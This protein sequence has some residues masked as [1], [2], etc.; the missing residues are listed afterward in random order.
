MK[1]HTNIQK[2][3]DK[4]KD[5]SKP[6]DRYSS[7]DYCYNYFLKTK[8]KDI[9]NNIEKSCLTLGF[10]LA[11]WG[12]FRNSFLLDKSIKHYEPTVR[13]IASL[14]KKI[15]KI[16]VDKYTVENIEIILQIYKDLKEH[17]GVENKA[18]R[19]LITKIM[20]GVFGFI[21]AYDRNFLKT[22]GK[23]FKNKC[24][25]TSVSK[26]SLICLKEFYDE[27]NKIIDTI[28]SKTFTTNFATGNKSK[29]KYPKAK[30]IDMYGFTKGMN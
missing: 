23:I 30:I 8:P 16:D 5:R 9:T 27:N 13:Y 22:F 14:D 12:M 20:L 11:S 19:T 29:I 3:I 15:W 2:N 10:Y 21:P 17:I 4:Y 28:S 6:H 18:H 25:F 26:K 7:F 24:S 1:K